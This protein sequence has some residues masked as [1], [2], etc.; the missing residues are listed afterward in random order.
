MLF[1]IGFFSLMVSAIVYQRKLFRKQPKTLLVY[2]LSIV[3]I[4]LH[5]FDMYS[6]PLF[7]VELPLLIEVI[8]RILPVAIAFLVSMSLK[9]V[10]ND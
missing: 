5:F 4:C 9:K 6:Y 3:Y 7:E 1:Y 8:A 10:K 2:I